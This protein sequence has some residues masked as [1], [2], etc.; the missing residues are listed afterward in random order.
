MPVDW[1]PVLK[2]VAGCLTVAGVGT[3]V[4][5][6]KIES[7]Q[8]RLEHLDVTVGDINAPGGVAEVAL[9]PLTILHLSDLHLCHPESHKVRFLQEITDADYDLV[10]LT[11]DIFENFSGLV[12]ASSILTRRPRLGAY[13]VLGNHDYYNYRLFHKTV[14]RLMRK[15]R[16]PPAKRD[17]TPMVQALEAGGFQVLRNEA[18]AHP[19]SRLHVVGIDY[20]TVPEDTLKELTGAAAAGHMVLVL[21]HV[22]LRLDNISRAGAHLAL[23]GH[24]HGGQVRIPGY[25]AIITDSELPRHEASGLFWRGETAFHVSRGLG[26]DP[27]SNIRFFCP[28]AATVLNVRYCSGRPGQV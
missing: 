14:G 25:G 8:Y 10:V 1:L 15:F 17:V 9:R 26:A 2:S 21:F 11:G 16:H 28:P 22:P 18:V 23:G 13:A 6:T 7:R 12:Y 20:P 24:T 3:L 5:A 19:E 27:R 4:Y